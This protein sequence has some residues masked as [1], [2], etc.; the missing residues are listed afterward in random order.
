MRG[1]QPPPRPPTRGEKPPELRPWEGGRCWRGS[2][3]GVPPGHPHVPCPQDEGGLS[4]WVSSPARCSGGVTGWRGVGGGDGVSLGTLSPLSPSV[5][6]CPQG[7]PTPTPHPHPRVTGRAGVGKLCPRHRW[8]LEGGSG[9][10]KLGRSK[11]ARRAFPAG[12]HLVPGDTSPH[13]PRAAP[14]SGDSRAAAPGVLRALFWDVVMG[15]TI[16]AAGS[17]HQWGQGAGVG[18]RDCGCWWSGCWWSGCW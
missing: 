14:R 12:S 3:P 2:V 18:G 16:P 9:A 17:A 5:P 1:T 11:G 13:T 10:V 4:P 8:R 15:L 6:G 7:H